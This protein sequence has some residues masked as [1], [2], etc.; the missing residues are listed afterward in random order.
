MHLNKEF[1]LKWGH[2]KSA[3]YQNKRCNKARYFEGYCKNKLLKYMFEK[4]LE[5][6]STFCLCFMHY[7]LC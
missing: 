5:I 6:K 7:S 4:Y 3:M 1:S 2:D